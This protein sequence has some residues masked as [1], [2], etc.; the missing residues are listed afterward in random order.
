MSPPEDGIGTDA[1]PP[2]ASPEEAARAER[3]LEELLQ[4]LKRVRGFDFTG[5]KRASLG[6]RIERRMQ[7]V[8]IGRFGDYLRHLEATP[9]EFA[10]LFNTVLINVTSFFRDGSPWEV[11]R[12]TVIPHILA[13]KEP[14]DPVR[15]WSAGCATGEEAYSLAIAF[16]EAMS[17][18]GARDRLK[19]YATDVDEEALAQARQGVYHDRAAANVPAELRERHFEHADGR[20][21]LRKELR[22]LVIFGRN[23]LIQDAPISR[24][25]LLVCRNT[26]MYFD[27]ATQAR[28]LAR[29]HFALNDR[30]FLLLGRAETVLS[31]L[32]TFAPVDLKRRVFTKIAR[33][34]VR[35]RLLVASRAAADDGRPS[36]SQWQLRQAALEHAP[37]AQLLMSRDGTLVAANAR[38]RALF[39][40]TTDD[41]GRPLHD[42]ELSY[43][44]VQLR[45]RI[46]QAYADRRPVT[47]HDVEWRGAA[48][49]R[50]LE[51]HVTPLPDEDGEPMGVAVAFVDVTAQRALQLELDQSHQERESAYEELQSTNEEL[52]TTNEELQATNEELQTLNDELRRRGDELNEV[53]DILE[54]IFTSVRSGIVVLDRDLDVLVWN[55]RA[56]DLWGARHAAVQG[57]SF[58]A[59][60]IGLPVEQL[61]GPLRSTVAGEREGFE[62]SL[63]ATNRRGRAIT[64]RISAAPLVGGAER[65]A[66][67]VIL[68]LEEEDSA[69]G[70][71]AGEETRS[72]H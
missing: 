8:G 31:H 52:E 5:Y 39:G 18:D 44:P 7:V 68:F 6:R 55:A 15:V 17:L 51:V 13:A 35:D 48:E 50:S 56:E 9:G 65:T 46:Q 4:Y 70:G 69:E 36:S 29:F 23:D 72:R 49:A 61:K 19:I 12:D 58:F 53:N 62:L 71:E 10:Q 59:L 2:G 42:L 11:V 32:S 63:A 67:G 43:R 24:I 21:T 37:F 30:G 40:L 1:Q 27:A 41:V 16:V 22:R 66:R 47:L 54:S 25:D 28:I 14:T 38:A 60:D 20:H 34:S 26:L 3:E 57:S 33:A 45:S 64:C